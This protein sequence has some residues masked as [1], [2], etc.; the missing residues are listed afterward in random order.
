[1]NAYLMP[2]NTTVNLVKMCR[3]FYQKDNGLN[4]ALNNPAGSTGNDF[5]YE[6]YPGILY[7]GLAHY[8]PNEP[9]LLTNMYAQAD[10]WYTASYF[11][12][13]NVGNPNYNYV[14]YDHVTH[15]TIGG[16]T[17]PDSAA[18]IATIEYLAYKK[19]GASQHLQGAEWAMDWYNGRT[20]NPAYELLYAWG[21]HTAARMNA[22]LGKNYE[23][24]KMLNWCFD[25]STYRSGTWKAQTGKWGNES[26]D[27][28]IGDGNNYA[29]SM[30][31]WAMA[32]AL[33]PVARYD[34]R[35]ARAIGKWMLNLANNSR[36]FL[37]EG[38]GPTYQSDYN[39]NNSV[40]HPIPYEGLKKDVGGKKPFATGDAKGALWAATNLSLY[41]GSHIGFLGG[42]FNSTNVSGVFQI[43]CNKTDFFSDPSYSTF[44]YYNPNSTVA[45]VNVP[46]PSGTFHLYDAVSNTL[47]AENKTGTANFTLPSDHA[48]VIIIV[49]TNVSFTASNGKIFAGS[50]VIRYK[51][52]DVTNDT[53]PSSAVFKSAVNPAQNVEV[54]HIISYPNPFDDYTTIKY[55]LNEKAYVKLSVFDLSGRLVS[56]LVNKKKEAGEHTVIWKVTD[57]SYR[58]Q[59]SAIYICKITI[60][61]KTPQKSETIKLLF[62]DY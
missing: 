37:R 4:I 14:S 49:P 3:T 15:A 35:F 23:V 54:N 6:I 19:W 61:G 16:S 13:G 45:T 21:V 33:A 2:N 1:M 42:I 8:Y 52:P 31:G 24:A 25:T 18:G 58:S 47:V 9:E 36:L 56:T 41:S 7:S 62:R 29:F 40:P 34:Y 43:N 48:K 26:V 50:K 39:W 30:N 55:Q 46:L 27:G 5:W 44:I 28:L 60:E 32:G 22:D 20:A 57:D 10:K 59:S 12:G 51:N 38:I 53:P 11:M 17:Q